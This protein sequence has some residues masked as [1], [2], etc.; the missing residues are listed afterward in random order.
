LHKRRI[1]SKFFCSR[2]VPHFPHSAQCPNITSLLRRICS[3]FQ[4][5]KPD[6]NPIYNVVKKSHRSTN[7]PVLDSFLEN[8]GNVGVVDLMLKLKSG[9]TRSTIL[10]IERTFVQEVWLVVCEA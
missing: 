3:R 2:S 1:L 9:K 7:A 8:A 4:V 5:Y 10:R 6:Y